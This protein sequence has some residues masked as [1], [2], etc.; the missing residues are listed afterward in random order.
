MANIGGIKMNKNDG[1]MND[2]KFTHI[3]RILTI[4]GL[5]V[6]ILTGAFYLDALINKNQE[7]LDSEGDVEDA[8]EKVNEAFDA[9]LEAIQDVDTALGDLETAH[10]AVVTAQD[11]LIQSN[12]ELET[13]LMLWHH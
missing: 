3:I 8:T 9:E 1:T 5:L 7:V 12:S 6:I 11:A 4:L 13:S 2:Y 10:D